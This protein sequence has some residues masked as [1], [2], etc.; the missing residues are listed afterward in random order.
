MGV[1][2]KAQETKAKANKWDHIKLEGFCT[3]QKVI[4]GVK[5]QQLGWKRTSANHISDKG[6]ILK[7][8]KELLQFNSKK[9][10][11]PNKPKT[12]KQQQKNTPQNK[13]N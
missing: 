4:K 9:K 8:C 1:T 11:K 2:Q 6:L 3:A 7:I 12:P 5:R 10:Q 13:N